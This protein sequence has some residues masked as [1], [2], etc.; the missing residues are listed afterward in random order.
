MK[1]GM[2][3]EAVKAV[4]GD[5]SSSAGAYF[6]SGVGEE[7]REDRPPAFR[8]RLWMWIRAAASEMKNQLLLDE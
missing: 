7:G 6:V 5:C 1:R 8:K 4:E 2:G 3:R